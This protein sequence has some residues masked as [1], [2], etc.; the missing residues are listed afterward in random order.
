LGN[1]M[2]KTVFIAIILVLSFAA[3]RSFAG[4]MNVFVSILP[5]KYFV[6]RIGGGLVDV[7]VMVSPGANP[8]AYEPK[9]AQ[10]VKI[11]KAVVYFAIGVPFENIWLERFVSINKKMTVVHTDRW[12]AKRSIA[13]HDH[14]EA[15]G[16]RGHE[17]AAADPHIW[18][19]PP[20]VMLQA[21]AIL[22][23]LA[24]ADPAN[25][26]EYDKN[27]KGF[28]AELV[29]LDLS[30]QGIIGQKRDGRSF[31][32]FHPS[33]GYFADA[34]G[35]K[36]MPIELEGKEPKPAQLK[37]LIEEGRAMGVKA[38]FVQPQ[39]SRRNAEVVAEAIGAT[40]VV[41]DPLAENWARNLVEVARRIAGSLR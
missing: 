24:A 8:H 13:D 4:G 6:D 9:P 38:I 12:I 26:S 5:Q 2:K 20:L 1:F 32:V 39:F 22:D 33:W 10:M 30:I 14:E 41:A 35:L 11:S 3:G 31:M 17:H 19:S 36:E 18:L 34:Y 16:G 37:G 27:Y 21:R 28:I 29:D 23:G 7:S 40:V 15:G 25:R